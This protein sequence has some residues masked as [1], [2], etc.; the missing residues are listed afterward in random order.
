MYD[1]LTGRAFQN[2]AEPGMAEPS[3]QGR[4]HSVFWK[5]RPVRPASQMEALFLGSH[6]LRVSRRVHQTI[7]LTSILKPNLV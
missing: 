2:C 1:G 4:I 5:A 6:M 7:Q 3:V